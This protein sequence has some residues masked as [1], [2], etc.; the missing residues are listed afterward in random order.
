MKKYE[1]KERMESIVSY[2]DE[3]TKEELIKDYCDINGV[4]DY[5]R[6]SYID[7]LNGYNGAFREADGTISTYQMIRDCADEILEEREGE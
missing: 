7:V 6:D 1:I 3:I 4:N 5:A 2:A